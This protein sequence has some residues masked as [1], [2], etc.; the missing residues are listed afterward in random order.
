MLDPYGPGRNFLATLMRPEFTEVFDW[1]MEM[2]PW[3]R[4]AVGFAVLAVLGVAGGVAVY[5]MRAEDRNLGVAER[6]IAEGDLRRAH[7]LL[8]QAVQVNPES[9]RAQVALGEFLDRVGAPHAASRW[10]VLVLLTGEDRFRWRQAASL[11][12]QG[13]FAAAG[14]V[15]DEVSPAGQDA[16]E[17]HR[18][19]AGLAL[20]RGDRRE[21]ER[22]LDAMVRLEPA[23][24]RSRFA[25]AAHR[26]GERVA[27]E[28]SRAELERLAKAGPLRARATLELMRDAP[29]RWPQAVDPEELLAARLLDGA[30]GVHLRAV[31]RPGR[32]RL[33]EH[34]KAP[35][36]PPPSDASVVIGWLAAEGRAGEA[37]QWSEALPDETQLHP[38]VL[39]A[40]AEAALLARDWVRLE[41][42]LSRGAWGQVAPS[43][44][45]E[46]FALRAEQE[47]G[48]AVVQARWQALL[49]SQ[50]MS[51]PA[52]RALSRLAFVWGRPTEGERALRLLLRR[53]PDEW[54]AWEEL[55]LQVI[56]R[57]EAE[58]LRQLAEE[59]AEAMP[60]DVAAERMRLFA[61]W[62]TRRGDPAL[63]NEVAELAAR[64]PRDAGVAVVQALVWRQE[65]RGAEALR[66]LD[67]FGGAILAAPRGPLVLGV[68]LAEAG[69]AEDAA[70]VLRLVQEPL[71]PEERRLL[72]DAKNRLGLR[73]R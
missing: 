19:R 64:A 51:V 39:A 41:R 66:L 27:V 61:R 4:R 24:L 54:R 49:E 69:R 36:F 17:H 15:L 31:A 73:E 37:L 26:L 7:L 52:L 65:G 30:G 48:S 72:E 3:A 55:S 46:A 42:A 28:E 70:A 47:R 23:N 29:R 33:I 8:E 40:G 5:L 32:P 11:L 25:L 60:R 18:I 44:V 38:S 59:W 71:F 62:L 9:V 6:L 57:G 16:L 45:R 63:P 35:P 10:E 13:A 20:A 68:L 12:G 14:A 2:K 1:W 58:A 22:H 34:V 43:V 21:V 56:R 50:E 67:G 53:A